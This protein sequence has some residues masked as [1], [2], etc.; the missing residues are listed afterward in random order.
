MKYPNNLLS[1]RNAKGLQ[2]GTVAN[3]IKMKQPEYSKME[4]GERR[5]GDHLSK[6]IEFFGV[7]E[8]EILSKQS[9]TKTGL[10][11]YIPLY[12]R[13]SDNPEGIIIEKTS[14]IFTKRP[15]ILENSEDGYAC[16]VIG[17]AMEPRYSKNDI[18]YIDPSQPT[19]VDDFVVIQQKSEK[20][21]NG[22]IR[23]IIEIRDRQ[24][25]FEALNRSEATK[26]IKNSDIFILNK[27]VGTA[28]FNF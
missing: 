4:R 2:Q 8:Q 28:N 22:I 6:L 13:R 25:K 17:D 7:H 19:Y 1:L 9:F 21:L 10:S 26:V 15:S 5:I 12:S 23:K 3:A 16:L 24:M 18:V 20:G 14:D 11:Q 27:I